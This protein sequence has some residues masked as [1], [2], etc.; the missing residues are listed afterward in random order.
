MAQNEKSESQVQIPVIYIYIYI[1]LC[2]N[3]HTYKYP[4]LLSPNIGTDQVLLPWL[5]SLLQKET[6]AYC[7]EIS[8]LFSHESEDQRTPRHVSLITLVGHIIIPHLK[9]SDT[10]GTTEN[11][12]KLSIDLNKKNVW[13]ILRALQKSQDDE[14]CTIKLIEQWFSTDVP[15]Y[16][17]VPTEDLRWAM[18][19][20][21]RSLIKLFSTEVQSTINVD[22]KI[23]TPLNWLNDKELQLKYSKD[24]TSFWFVLNGEFQSIKKKSNRN[25]S[26]LSKVIFVQSNL[27]LQ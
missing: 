23:K 9:N 5:A 6:A 25:T 4:S 24:I 16:A 1:H 19:N 26:S 17:G 12:L 15:W 3:A 7:R 18:K 10:T 27:L 14:Q 22:I 2:I 20:F 8:C 21:E 11:I 13:S